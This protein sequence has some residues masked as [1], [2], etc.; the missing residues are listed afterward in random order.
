MIL[1]CIC[2]RSADMNSFGCAEWLNL[3]RCSF[4]I[5][6]CSNCWTEARANRTIGMRIGVTFALIGLVFDERLEIHQA[7]GD[8]IEMWIVFVNWKPNGHVGN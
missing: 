6:Q 4:E 2:K 8:V 5:D 1:D 3:S 7:R